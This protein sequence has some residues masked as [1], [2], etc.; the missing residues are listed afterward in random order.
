MKAL[1][2]NGKQDSNK[3]GGIWKIPSEYNRR[4]GRRRETTLSDYL[5][6]SFLQRTEHCIKKQHFTATADDFLIDL[7]VTSV[8]IYRQEDNSIQEE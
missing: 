1:E 2:V 7:T 4:V 6:T 8:S 5:V 3:R